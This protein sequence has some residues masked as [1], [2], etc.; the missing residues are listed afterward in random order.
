MLEWDVGVG[1]WGGRLWR[2]DALLGDFLQSK[3]S[4]LGVEGILLLGAPST[5]SG[6]RGAPR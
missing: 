4:L 6:G 2:A 1:R 5:A 3:K